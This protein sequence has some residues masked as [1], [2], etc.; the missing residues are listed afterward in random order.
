[1]DTKV[2]PLR[3]TVSFYR[4]LEHDEVF[5]WKLNGDF[6][7]VTPD[8]FHYLYHIL[9]D[10]RAALKEDCIEYV[11]YNLYKSLDDYPDWFTEAVYDGQIIRGQ[12][13]HIFIDDKGETAMSPEAIVLRNY[14]GDLRYMERETF[15]KMYVVI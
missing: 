14:M 5:V 13:I 10:R 15:N 4:Y 2:A 6:T 7:L 8:S 1:M 12:S 9:D 3:G 11:V